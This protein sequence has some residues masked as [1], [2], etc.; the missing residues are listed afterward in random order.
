[1]HS[2]ASA[3]DVRPPFAL[4]KVS[5]SDLRVPSASAG[6]VHVHTEGKTSSSKN[7]STIAAFTNP[8]LVQGPSLTDRLGI[9]RMKRDEIEIPE[10]WSVPRYEPH[11]A[12]YVLDETGNF[13][14][15]GRALNEG[16]VPM[17]APRRNRRLLAEDNA[18][19]AGWKVPRYALHMTRKPTVAGN[20]DPRFQRQRDSCDTKSLDGHRPIP[21]MQEECDKPDGWSVKRYAPH[22]QN[23]VSHPSF[24]WRGLRPSRASGS[25]QRATSET[26]PETK[27]TDVPDG[28]RV[29]RYAVTFAPSK[30][31]VDPAARLHGNVAPSRFSALPAFYAM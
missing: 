7:I 5:R 19:P 20:L 12:K 16:P 3:P 9:H 4:T 27:A 31:V 24:G 14:R 30:N 11:M 10:K 1:M 21:A 18:T 8:G 2:S 29:P 15:S 23:F 26:M 22:M 17:V 28:W 25:S 13:L 6:E